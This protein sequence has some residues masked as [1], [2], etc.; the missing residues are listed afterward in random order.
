L[1]FWK[2]KN[3]IPKLSRIY[4]KTKASTATKSTE[5]SCPIVD[6]TIDNMLS[7]FLGKNISF[8]LNIIDLD[9][10]SG[11]QKMVLLNQFIIPGGQVTT[12]KSI[13]NQIKRPDSVRAV[14]NALANNP[15]PIIIPC[16]RTVKS[17]GTPGGYQGGTQMKAQLLEM[18]GI[19]FS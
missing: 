3:G 16:H 18:E 1:I 5:L 19:E 15:F 9:I 10:C 4:L 8:S 14:G 11:F 7:Y 12:Y 17:D 6:D 2:L 13:A